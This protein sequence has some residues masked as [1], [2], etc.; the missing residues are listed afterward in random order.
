M[1]LFTNKTLLITGAY[2]GM[3]RAAVRRFVADGYTVFALD[4]RTDAAEEGIIP[5]TADLRD[6]ESVIAAVKAVSAPKTGDMTPVALLGTMMILSMLAAAALVLQ[7]K[8]QKA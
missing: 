3:G 8:K 2:G 7:T 5:I 1:S 4:I 6:E